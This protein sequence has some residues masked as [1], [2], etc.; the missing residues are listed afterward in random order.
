[1]HD[2]IL[3]QPGRYIRPRQGYHYTFRLHAFILRSEEN[4]MSHAGEMSEHIH[5]IIDEMCHAKTLADRPFV[6]PLPAKME[7]LRIE[8]KHIEQL[9]IREP[10]ASFLFSPRTALR[11]DANAL[12]KPFAPQS[13]QSVESACDR[14]RL[15][16]AIREK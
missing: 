6:W 14:R 10:K 9:V 4:P 15:K 11:Y 5:P 3:K 12:A 13:R 8:T 7:R 2:E 16:K 1:M